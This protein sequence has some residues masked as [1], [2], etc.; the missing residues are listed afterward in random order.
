MGSASASGDVHRTAACLQDV[1][2]ALGRASALIGAVFP[3]QCPSK[4]EIVRLRTKRA[5]GWERR[6]ET[7]DFS[8]LATRP[9]LDL[10]GC[11]TKTASKN[12]STAA[13]SHEFRSADTGAA[14]EGAG[15]SRASFSG[16]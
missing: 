11:L 16:L 2:T 13:E 15:A 4:P 14:G 3:R 7:N 5:S 1:R 6:Q 12:G 9:A 8:L 10:A